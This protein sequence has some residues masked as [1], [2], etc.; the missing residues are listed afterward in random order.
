[1]R[2][3]NTVDR[4]L[5]ALLGVVRLELAFFWLGGLWRLLAYVAGA[6]LLSTSM[7]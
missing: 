6:A 7:P 1:M 2:N 5:R 4:L 3:L